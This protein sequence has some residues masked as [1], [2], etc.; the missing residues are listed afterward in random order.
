MGADLYIQSIV[1]TEEGYFRD[2][3]NDSCVLWALG[4]SW[5]DDVWPRLDEERFLLPEQ[6][7]WLLGEIR[8]REV[9]IPQNIQADMGHTVA[10]VNYHLTESDEIK[11]EI[12]MVWHTIEDWQD[13]YQR[14][15]ERMIAFLERAI[16]MDEPIACSI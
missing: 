16:A 2:N 3:Y 11:G 4:L 9:E 13:D 6:V 5:G 14:R 8:S 10:L 1:D 7:K 12:K 15:R